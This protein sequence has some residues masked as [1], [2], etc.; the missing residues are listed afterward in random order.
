MAAI[1]FAVD[2]GGTFTDVVATTADGAR[3]TL[4]LLSVDPSHYADAPREGIRRLLETLTGA[5]HP[6]DAPLATRHIHSIRMGTTV[7]TNALLERTGAR[8][9]L[10]ITRGFGDLLRIGTQARPRIFS[11][12]ITVP[13]VLYERVVEVD[14]RVVVLRDGEPVPASDPSSAIDG[15]AAALPATATA[16]VVTGVTGER[17]AV[18]RP[19]DVAAVRAQLAEL[20]AAGLRNVAVVLMHAYTFP[21][22]ERAVVAAARAVGFTHVTCSS[23][24]TPTVKIVPRGFT[25]TAD[26]YL[27]PGIAQYIAGFCGGFAG[28]LP[29]VLFMQSDGGLTP[30]D[31]FSG[32]KAILSG[33][34]G[35]V[36][37]Y[38]Q[39]SFVARLGYMPVIGFDMGGT[40]T[41]VSRYAGHYDHVFE[42]TTAG[43]TIQAP[44]LDINTVAAGGGS[45]LVVRH[46]MFL[47]VCTPLPLQAPTC[48][49]TQ[50]HI[51][52]C[53]AL[54]M[55]PATWPRP[56]AS[57]HA[58]RPSDVRGWG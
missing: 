11:L 3:H 45:C 21:A 16:E 52:T 43:V 8:C 46:G 10:L 48:S 12:D 55:H 5:P 6:R 7:A 36:V 35:G 1:R 44:Q 53:T 26:A 54:G 57:D 15:D 32:Y 34:A 41:D 38:A 56:N 33:P 19:L 24:L 29:P 50:S 31:A 42:T 47:V 27:T 13:D 25:A 22:H 4:K 51:D 17:V 49:H 37:G 28:P 23:A 18:V 2:R 40:S 58:P 14:E 20:Y 9:A 30:M 39:T